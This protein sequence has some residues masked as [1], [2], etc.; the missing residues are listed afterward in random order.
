MSKLLL[1]AHTSR[2]DVLAALRALVPD[3]PLVE[4]RNHLAHGTPFLERIYPMNDRE[5]VAHL[6]RAVL[7]V[8][9]ANDVEPIAYIF[10]DEDE[11]FDATT[12]ATKRE[13]VAHL[14]NELHLP[15]QIHADF[16]RL[17]KEGHRP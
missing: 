10:D 5:E 12:S 16:E 14:E 9:R 8:L 6:F 15:E 4:L 7:D 11:E 17:A 13:P 1:G 2:T 3:V